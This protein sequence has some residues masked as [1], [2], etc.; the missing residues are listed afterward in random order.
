MAKVVIEN[1]YKIYDGDKGR[2]ITPLRTRISLLTIANSLCSSGRRVA[3]NP[4]PCA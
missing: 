1:I 3:E 2:E 4:L